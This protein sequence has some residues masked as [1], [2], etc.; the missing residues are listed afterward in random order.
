[1]LSNKLCLLELKGR[2]EKQRHLHICASSSNLLKVRGACLLEEDSRQIW[3][4]MRGF[5]VVFSVHTLCSC[6]AILH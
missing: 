6:F 3:L 1:V 5:I 4:Q 2:P